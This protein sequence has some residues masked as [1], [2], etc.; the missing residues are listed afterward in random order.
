MAEN[1]AAPF[2]AKMNGTAPANNPEKRTADKAVTRKARKAF[3]ARARDVTELEAKRLV[4]PERMDP[5]LTIFDEI[6][7]YFG[8][9]G[10]IKA[11]QHD[12]NLISRQLDT[13]NKDLLA[14]DTTVRMRGDCKN[15]NLSAIARTDICLKTGKTMDESGAMRRGEYEDRTPDFK[16]PD[17]DILRAKYPIEQYPELHAMLD[18]IKNED[19]QEYFMIDCNRR[20]FVID[21]PEEVTDLKDQRF[22]A[23]LMADEIR[24]VLNHPHLP[25]PIPFHYEM[26][27]ECEV[28]FKPCTYDE[29]PEA[30]SL[31]TDN[32]LNKTQVNDIMAKIINHI[33]AAAKGGLVE[34]NKSKA[35]RGF[36]ALERLERGM[37]RY[38]DSNSAYAN[39]EETVEALKKRGFLRSIFEMGTFSGSPANDN[40]AIEAIR[41]DV[42]KRFR[43][44]IAR[45]PI[46]TYQDGTEP[47]AANAAANA[48]PQKPGTLGRN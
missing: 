27:V 44:S 19:L 36:E 1:Y 34:T 45:R 18:G 26:E 35:D 14:I 11:S 15:H 22:V 13:K 7:N 38:L 3:N 29:R 43:E 10:W 17:L 32:S 6:E 41:D 8:D 46:A 47:A 12:I 5:D 23:E 42:M 40:K 30:Q 9:A 16:T 33:D 20:R 25:M 28:L 37:H 24:F 31:F 48:R 2:R 4:R 21:V 39:R